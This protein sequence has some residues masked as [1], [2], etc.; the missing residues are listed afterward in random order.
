MKIV[1][2][3]TTDYGGAYEATQRINDCLVDCGSESVV[4]VRTRAGDTASVSF[5]NSLSQKIFSKVKNF[6]F[7]S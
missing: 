6:G 2:L 1:H 7:I 3:S 5:Y 4:L